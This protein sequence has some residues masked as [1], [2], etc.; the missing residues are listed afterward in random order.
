M[1]KLVLCCDFLAAV[2]LTR[3]CNHGVSLL[4]PTVRCVVQFTKRCIHGAL[5]FC[6]YIRILVC[7]AQS[8]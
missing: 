3:R 1:V 2:K 7:C 6:V 4:L 8:V 5:A